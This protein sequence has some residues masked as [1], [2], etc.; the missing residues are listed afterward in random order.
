M[1][2]A[3]LLPLIEDCRF[4]A[5]VN[6]AS[7]RDAF[8]RALCRHPRVQE[9]QQLLEHRAAAE[10]LVARLVEISSRPIDPQYENPLD[11]ALAAYL[12][13]LE[14]APYPD[15]TESGA[16]AISTTAPNCWWAVEASTRLLRRE[17]L[18]VTSN[19]VGVGTLTIRPMVEMRA[20]N[21]TAPAAA[22]SAPMS[23]LT[24]RW[25][26]PHNGTAI[27]KGSRSAGHRRARRPTKK[28]A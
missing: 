6:V 26:L 9:L 16:L 22:S 24:N 15:L 18:R 11:S 12:T 3:N 27:A 14:D 19:A 8:F 28:A 5:E 4:S 25:E 21:L 17:R 20:G 10:A 1:T 13:A 23:G 7:A 2:L